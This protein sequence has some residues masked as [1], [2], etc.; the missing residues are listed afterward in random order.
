MLAGWLLAA[1]LAVACRVT[2]EP[3][4]RSARGVLIDVAAT[5]LT[6]VRS[7]DLRADDGR[8]LSFR[9]EGDVGMTPGHLREH[10]VLGEPITVTYRESP[11]GLLAL[12]VED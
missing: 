12:R 11:D 1:S 9:A 3:E 8:R 5:S 10:M 7:F 6:S 4:S 2:P